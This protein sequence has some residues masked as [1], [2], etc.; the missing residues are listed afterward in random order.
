[1]QALQFLRLWDADAEAIVFGRN[2]HRTARIVGI[3]KVRQVGI[4]AFAAQQLLEAPFQLREV[5]SLVREY[6]LTSLHSLLWAV[7][8]GDFSKQCKAWVFD[9]VAVNMLDIYHYFS[10][11]FRC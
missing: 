5:E 8:M 2:L 4:A 11:L 1:M 6:T 10:T 3:A 7:F 9:A